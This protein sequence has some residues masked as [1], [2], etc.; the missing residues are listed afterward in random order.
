[1]TGPEPDAAAAVPVETGD[2]LIE[3]VP[4]GG[5]RCQDDEH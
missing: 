4:S 5:H 2:P 1:M 3:Q